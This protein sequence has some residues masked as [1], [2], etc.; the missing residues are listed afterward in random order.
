[1][2]RARRLEDL[3]IIVRPDQTFVYTLSWSYCWQD[4]ASLHSESLLQNFSIQLNFPRLLIPTLIIN[5]LHPLIGLAPLGFKH[6]CHSRLNTLYHLRWETCNILEYFFALPLC[7]L[8]STDDFHLFSAKLINLTFHSLLQVKL[9]KF[10]VRLCFECV[11]VQLRPLG[12]NAF[13]RLDFVFEYL[14]GL[15]LALQ[16]LILSLSQR[17]L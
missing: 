16:K 5:T 12:F 10:V 8:Q 13:Q 11:V 4:W 1:M 3:R 9:L 6:I 17:A 14:L 15:L 2:Y 7:I